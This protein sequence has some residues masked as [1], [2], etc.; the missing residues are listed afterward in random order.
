MEALAIQ[1]GLD[2]SRTHKR[3]RE[4]L[5]HAI[6]QR[7]QFDSVWMAKEAREA[8][9]QPIPFLLQSTLK[10]LVP[11]LEEAEPERASR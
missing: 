6:E 8:F 3:V 11:E 1:A 9:K 5:R 7:A 4:N 2:P 10:S